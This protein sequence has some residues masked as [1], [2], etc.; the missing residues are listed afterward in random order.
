MFYKETEAYAIVNIFQGQKFEPKFKARV[1]T[2]MT[3]AFPS[4]PS[5]LFCFI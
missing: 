3:S 4:I 1:L 2:L 5:S